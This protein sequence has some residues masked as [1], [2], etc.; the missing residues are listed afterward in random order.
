[1]RLTTLLL[2]GSMLVAVSA[3][4]S[5]HHPAALATSGTAGPPTQRSSPVAASGAPSSAVVSSAASVSPPPVPS[6]RPLTTRATQRVTLRPVTAA[7]QPG[8]GYRVTTETWSRF[9]CTDGPSPVAVSPDIRFCGPSASNTVACWK[10]AVG[11]SVL[12]LRD[13]FG[14]ILVRIAYSGTFA[15]VDPP[16]SPAPQ[17]LVL[18]NG[19]HCQLRDGGAWSRLDQHPDWVGWYE[20]ANG[21]DVYGPKAGD[22]IDRSAAMWTVH[23]VDGRTLNPSTGASGPI[24]EHGVARAYYDGTA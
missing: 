11:S 13:P 12:C 19:T 4:T 6:S 10:F 21:A 17:G 20:C 14:Q 5:A 1:M 3:C 24:T 9:Q 22:G 8:A 18:T 15:P 2:A 23:T 16:A 7:G